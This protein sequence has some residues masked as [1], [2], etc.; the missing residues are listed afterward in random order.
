M[1]RRRML[2]SVNGGGSGGLQFPITLVA[3][4]NGEDGGE[5]GQVGIDV[6]NYLINAYN[7]Q[8]EYEISSVSEMLFIDMRIYGGKVD[9]IM[10]KP[11][12]KDTIHLGT[13]ICDE[14]LSMCHF[15]LRSSGRLIL[16]DMEGGGS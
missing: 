14:L 6:F 1:I 10:S 4:M 8:T 2:M 13:P 11:V 9:K 16:I 5:N 3:C 7:F 15:E 12:K